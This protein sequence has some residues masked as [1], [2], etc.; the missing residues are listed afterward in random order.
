M[1]LCVDAPLQSHGVVILAHPQP[2]LGGSAQHKVP[3]FLA[4]ALAQAGWW[5][6]R[7]NFR[8]VGL[9][10]GRHDQGE[11]ETQDL[12]WLA[13]VVRA[14]TPELPMSLVGISF[15]AY[16]QACV[17]AHLQQHGHPAQ[18]VVLAAMP[19]GEVQGGRRYDTPQGLANTHLIHGE[20][21]ERVPLRSVLDWARPTSQAVCVVPGAD[22]LFSGKLPLLRDLTLAFLSSKEI[23]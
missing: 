22:H 1:E 14:Q 17:A 23:P 3:Q 18:H 10:A 5:V 12:I 15:G 16:V 2:L 6:L 9:S 21:D 7:P 13:G 4:K 20:M 19:Y 8:G 11:G